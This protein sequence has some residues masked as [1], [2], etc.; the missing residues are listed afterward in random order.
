[1]II[2]AKFVDL[3]IKGIEIFRVYL[4]LAKK[5][6]DD[7]G[8]VLRKVGETRSFRLAF[9]YIR[10]KVNFFLLFFFV[11]SI[12]ER[13][14]LISYFNLLYKLLGYIR[15]GFATHYAIRLESMKKKHW[16]LDA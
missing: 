14:E 16:I 15:H 5:T 12:Q 6:C 13:Q 11:S 7:G 9:T 4:H 2:F 1:M 8:T 3:K 10:N